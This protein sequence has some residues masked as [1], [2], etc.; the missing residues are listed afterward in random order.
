MLRR[1]S[2]VALCSLLAA[3]LHAHDLVIPVVTGTAPDRT[4]S[5]TVVVKNAA[6]TDAHCT[7]TYRGPERVDKPFISMETVPAGTTH[8]YED[9]LREIAAAGTVRVD[10]PSSVEVLARV[11]DSLNGGKSFRP[12]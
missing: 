5:T 1:S 10:C 11:Q 12:G 3:H 2:L 4:Y 8:V 9:F 7:F 6:T